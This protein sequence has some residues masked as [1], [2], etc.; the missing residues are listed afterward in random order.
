VSLRGLAI[1]AC[2]TVNFGCYKY[3]PTTLEAVSPGTAIR[4]V[5]SADERMELRN[6]LGL[7]VTELEGRL[8]DKTGDRLLLSVRL[9]SGA[10]VLGSQPL[11]QRI[12]LA[13]ADI[14]RLDER[15]VDGVRTAGLVG[16]F[17]T[18]TAFG[19]AQL[20]TEGDPGS[21]DVEPPSPS[22]QRQRALLRFTVIRW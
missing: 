16:A 19:I 13:P 1:C 4:T 6:T 18:V 15:K 20:F 14:M 8:I 21:P 11:N 17:A 7:N 5:L 9:A 12:E 22:E 2:A 10:Q 3:V